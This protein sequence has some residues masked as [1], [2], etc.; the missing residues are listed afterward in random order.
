MSGLTVI[1]YFL[2]VMLGIIAYR[3]YG[4]REAFS[5]DP[6][7]KIVSIAGLVLLGSVSQAI[8]PYVWEAVIWLWNNIGISIIH[9]VGTLIQQLPMLKK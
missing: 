9:W 7:R 6:G 1:Y 3:V 8:G 4:G 2:G 5:K